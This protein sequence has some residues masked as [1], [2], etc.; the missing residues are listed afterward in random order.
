[1]KVMVTGGTGFVGLN[2][3]EQLLAAGHEVHCLVRE[4]SNLKYLNNF[5][6]TLHYG[7]LNDRA[8]LDKALVGLQAVIH[9]AGNT[10]SYVWDRPLLDATNVVGTACV[11]QAALDAGITRFVYTS[12]TSTIGAPMDGQSLGDETTPLSGFRADNP[13]GQSKQEAEQV[14][15]GLMDQGLEPI[16]LNPAEVLGAW[17]HTMNWGAMVMAVA[18]DQV[19]FCPPG[20][21]TF[22]SAREVGRA[23]VNALSEGEAGQRYILGGANTSFESLIETCGQVIGRPASAPAMP[24]AQAYYQAYQAQYGH[25]YGQTLPLLDPYRMRVIKGH[26]LFDSARAVDALGYRCA[27]LEEMVCDALSWYRGNGFLPG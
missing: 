8:A 26:F 22:C 4:S 13:Y 19:P 25:A 21:A 18:A 5:A 7:Q 15:L 16:I 24:F 1:M 11:A 23:H 17:D 3:V 12:T 2:I 20:S 9:C 10:S 14:L 6:V 27:P